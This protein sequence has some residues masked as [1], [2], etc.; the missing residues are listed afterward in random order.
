MP[1]QFQIQTVAGVDNASFILGGLPAGITALETV[2][3]K[4]VGTTTPTE[5]RLSVCNFDWT[6]AGARNFE[7]QEVVTEKMVE[8]KI[9]AGPWTPIGGTFVT[10]GNYIE[11][12]L[13]A[14][15]AYVEVQLR[16]NVPADASTKGSCRFILV[17]AHS[18][19]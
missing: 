19:E 6:F 3:I 15:G 10:P 16:V 11:P 14:A 17:G 9:G 13:I 7:G 8:A 18:D 1:S 2:R 12:G 4:N 5:L